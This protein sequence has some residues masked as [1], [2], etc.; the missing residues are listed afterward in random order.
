MN[1]VRAIKKICEFPAASGFELN[2]AKRVLGILKRYV[3]DAGVDS[4]GNVI[5]IKRCGIKNARCLL[6]DAHI[7]EIGFI[8]TG[9]KDGFLRFSSLGSVDERVLPAME[10]LILTN[11]TV[12]GVVTCLP[13]HLQTRE[14]MDKAISKDKLYIDIGMSDEKA[15]KAVPVGTPVIYAADCVELQSGFVSGRALD[16][17]A[18]FV[19]LLYAL[20]LLKNKKLYV[21]IAVVGSVMEELGCRGAMVGGYSLNPDYAIVV[22]V[23]HAL[24]PGAPPDKCFE[25]GGG[26]AIGIGPNINRGMSD[27]LKRIARD[28]KI[29]YALEVMER[30]SGT[31]AWTLQTVREGIRTAVLSV[32]LRYMHTPFE[33]ICVKD[34]EH[35]ARLI[36]EYA[37]YLGKQVPGEL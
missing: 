25:A 9:Y 16:D 8:V 21:D 19:T 22:D 37:V 31:N 35:T 10:M 12:R 5:G 34:I 13:P 4:L 32:P 36:A 20:E 15:R 17:R 6:L 2:S 3:D 18:G 1:I 11:P 14:E 33:T 27:T 23:T 26:V 29:P 28:R 24:L 30:D 7:D